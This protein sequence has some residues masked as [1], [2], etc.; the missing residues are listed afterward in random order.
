VMGSLETLS[1]L[2]TVSRQY[3]HC[4]GLGLGLEGYWLGLD[5]LYTGEGYRPIHVSRSGLIICNGKGNMRT[6]LI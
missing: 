2:E 3:Y 5:S 1:R 4:L 6:F